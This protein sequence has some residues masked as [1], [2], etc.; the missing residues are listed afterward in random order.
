MQDIKL[1]YIMI[2]GIAFWKKVG[3]FLPERWH[4]SGGFM[5][6]NLQFP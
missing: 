2:H 6:I 5:P 4:E 3:T 1:F